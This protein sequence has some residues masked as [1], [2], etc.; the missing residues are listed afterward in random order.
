MSETEPTPET[1]T[2]ETASDDSD[3]EPI[4]SKKDLDRLIGAAR[5]ADRQRIAE[6]APKASKYEEAEKAKMT[7]AEQ[8]QAM[9]A[10]LQSELDAERQARTRDSAIRNILRDKGLPD[11]AAEFIT[12]NDPDELEASADRFLSIHGTAAKPKAKPSQLKS[13]FG[14]DSRMDPM[15]KAAAAMRNFRGQT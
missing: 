15:E 7:Q 9:I 8:D 3:F 1:T 14:A 4:T 6:L 10:R 5:K 2:P 13:S 12:G 11:E